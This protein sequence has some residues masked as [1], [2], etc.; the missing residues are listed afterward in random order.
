MRDN[1][2]KSLKKQEKHVTFSQK[3]RDK[4]SYDYYQKVEQQK[5][6]L[7]QISRRLFADSYPG[8]QHQDSLASNLEED[9][10]T[11]A[12]G[13]NGAAT[14]SGVSKG[15]KKSKAFQDEDEEC[16]QIEKATKE[17]EEIFH[18]L[19]VV[20]GAVK[21]NQVLERFHNQKRSTQHLNYLREQAEKEKAYLE[22]KNESLRKELES[23]KFS[24]VKE[25]ET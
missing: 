9:L 22:Q 4:Q 3:C 6:Q 21:P 2:R 23:M 17:M 19:T 12:E 18:T 1:A 20:T 16:R 8:L 13:G 7:E 25:K 10:S 14:S 5:Q 11:D 15:K 24:N